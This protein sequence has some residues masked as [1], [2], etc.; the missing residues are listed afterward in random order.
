MQRGIVVVTPA[1]DA[2]FKAARSSGTLNLSGKDL[3]EVP[4]EVYSLLDDVP[5]SE[6]W[7][8]A[9]EL[10]K[11]LLARNSLTHISEEIGRLPCLTWLD[12]SYNSLP[13]L[14]AAVGKVWEREP[15]GEGD[16]PP[17]LTHMA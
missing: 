10:Q 4:P 7:W 16:R 11:V 9:V 3:K 8:E 5:Q 12:V 15:G 2:V 14:P 13:R 6:K 1:L 17:A